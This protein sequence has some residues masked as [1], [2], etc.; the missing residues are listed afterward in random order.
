MSNIAGC[1]SDAYFLETST[2][3][4]KAQQRVELRKARQDHISFQN[5]IAF[6]AAQSIYVGDLDRS[7]AGASF[8]FESDSLIEFNSDQVVLPQ[9]LTGSPL[10]FPPCFPLLPSFLFSFSLSGARK[11][12]SFTS[13]FRC[14]LE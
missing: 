6:L 8:R 14:F 4:R 3:V 11:V 2:L 13:D 1:Q 5:E 9:D 12:L 10:P 7:S